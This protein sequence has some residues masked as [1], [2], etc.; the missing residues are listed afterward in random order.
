M[1]FGPDGDPIPPKF[2]KE[3][4]S[5]RQ[6]AMLRMADGTLVDSDRVLAVL[7]AQQRGRLAKR[8]SQ[9]WIGSMLGLAGSFEATPQE[10]LDCEPNTSMP[11]LSDQAAPHPER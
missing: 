11:P 6:A 10:L 7:D 4:F 3:A 5:E 2:L 9:A 1:V 8:P